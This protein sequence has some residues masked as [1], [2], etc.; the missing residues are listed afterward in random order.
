MASFCVTVYSQLQLYKFFAVE[1]GMGSGGETLAKSCT[2]E[3]VQNK[4]YMFLLIIQC[5][6]FPYVMD[7]FVIFL[8]NIS[9]FLRLNSLLKYL[10]TISNLGG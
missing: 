8:Y 2:Y 5:G 10:C 3:I 9:H 4:V 1:Q 7:N 6:S